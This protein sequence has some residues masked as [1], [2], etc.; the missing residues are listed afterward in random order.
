MTFDTQVHALETPGGDDDR[1][2]LTFWVSLA[3]PPL[4]LKAASPLC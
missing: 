2:W 4:A 1:Q 3:L